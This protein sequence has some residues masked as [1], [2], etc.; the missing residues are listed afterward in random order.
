LNF[1]LSLK[2]LSTNLSYGGA[3]IAVLGMEISLRSL[4]L[5][6][7][8]SNYVSIIINYEETHVRKFFSIGQS[9]TAHF[10]F[11]LC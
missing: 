3:L 7:R 10:T 2:F 6:K 8:D 5:N 9:F 11:G 1:L 4:M